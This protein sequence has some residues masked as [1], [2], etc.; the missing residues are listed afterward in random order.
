MLAIDSEAGKGSTTV[1][2][3]AA[4]EAGPPSEIVV[5]ATS[6]GL[7]PARLSIPVTTDYLEPSPRAAASKTVWR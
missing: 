2:N 6:D 3:P 7:A 5:E 4:I 1:A